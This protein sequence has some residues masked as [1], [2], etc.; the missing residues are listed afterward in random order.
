MRLGRLLT[1]ELGLVIGSLLLSLVGAELGLR[2]IVG[3]DP[4]YY[5]NAGSQRILNPEQDNPEQNPFGFPL[6][7]RMAIPSSDSWLAG[8]P[9]HVNA[10]GMRAP[11]E[12]AFEKTP[13]VL[14][15]LMIGDSVTWALT[16]YEDGLVD[17]LQRALAERRPDAIVE[18]PSF[19]CPSWTPSDYFIA[20]EKA[21]RRFELDHLVVNFV[22]NDLPPIPLTYDAS[23]QRARLD[24]GM[25]SHPTLRALLRHSALGTG[26]V[27]LTRGVAARS[28]FDPTLELLAA[29]EAQIEQYAEYVRPLFRALHAFE[30]ERGVPVTVALWPFAVQLDPALGRRVVEEW[31]GQPFD[32]RLLERR[33]Q[34]ILQRVCAEE[35]VDCRDASPAFLAQP[36]IEPLFFETPEGRIDYIHLSPEGHRVA[37]TWL[38][39]QIAPP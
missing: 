23:R 24:R 2:W 32:A 17:S 14:R 4:L 26:L 7:M 11:R 21:A 33:P 5:D 27:W 19:A 15:I 25:D 9:V 34:A 18:V 37:A 1:P 31:Y 39:E 8:K 30:A 6:G 10:Q 22:M 16:A 28:R 20:L 38:A 36:A 35:G 12:Y 3:I 29:P 13:G